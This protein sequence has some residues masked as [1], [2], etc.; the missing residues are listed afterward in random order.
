VQ[1]WRN[2]VTI[3]T[4][5]NSISTYIRDITDL[6]KELGV[7]ISSSSIGCIGFSTSQIKTSA[8]KAV[9]TA[10]LNKTVV[11]RHAVATNSE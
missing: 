10:A 9:N 3:Q 4:T 5:K 2:A 7:K 11:D 8:E 1:K 6:G